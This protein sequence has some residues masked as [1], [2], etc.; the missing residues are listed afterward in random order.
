[1]SPQS[2]TPLQTS[3][4]ASK[5]RFSFLNRTHTFWLGVVLGGLA[6]GGLGYGVSYFY[7]SASKDSVSVKDGQMS[8]SKPT[9]TISTTTAVS[10][11][12]IVT[13][14]GTGNA[15]GQGGSVANSGAG[16]E[17]TGKVES[18]TVTKQTSP[19]VVGNGNTITI[20]SDL[21]GFDKKSYNI[22]PPPSDLSKYTEVNDLQPDSLAKSSSDERKITFE[23]E[24]IIILGKPYTSFF[25]V[26][27][28][29]KESRYVFKLDGTQKAV[30]LQFG[31][32]DLPSSSTS[33]GNYVV[34]I[35]ADGQAL[36]AGECRR[37]QGN[38]IISV[39]LDIP[40]KSTLTI[41]VTSNGENETGLFFTKASLLKN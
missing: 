14:T 21:P 7:L 37:S 16:A 13:T 9:T 26:S 3:P 27:Y 24:D 2:P 4:Q 32:P 38:Q 35:Y 11:T 6:A 25:N 22:A 29:S 17:T 40:G 34:K 12:P 30:L 31:L 5:P 41:E 18:S 8:F 39:P 1:V 36:W 33:K 19:T 10:E 20:V 23:K 28:Y 15:T